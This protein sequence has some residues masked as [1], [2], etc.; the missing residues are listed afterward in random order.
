MFRRFH[1]RQFT[2]Y[3]VKSQSE[4]IGK[5]A[6]KFISPANDIAGLNRVVMSVLHFL[7]NY[8]KDLGLF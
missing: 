2:R 1:A 6:Q 7:T 3:R 5:I 4:I 8:D